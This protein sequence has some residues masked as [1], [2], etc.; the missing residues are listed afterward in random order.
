[1]GFRSVGIVG[2]LTRSDEPVSTSALM[3]IVAVYILDS[4]DAHQYHMHDKERNESGNET[5]DLS[6]A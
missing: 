4:I 3:R 5:H 1:M 6:A 2:A